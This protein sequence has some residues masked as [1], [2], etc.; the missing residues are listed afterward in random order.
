MTVT[1]YNINWQQVHRAW[2]RFLRQLVG[3]PRQHSAS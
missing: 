3:E 2:K 1:K